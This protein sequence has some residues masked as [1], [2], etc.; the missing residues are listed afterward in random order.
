M[1]IFWENSTII[2]RLMSDENIT[3]SVLLIYT[4]PNFHKEVEKLTEKD[5][6]S[7]I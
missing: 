3:Q 2:M 4:D 1:D 5:V 6:E 7:D